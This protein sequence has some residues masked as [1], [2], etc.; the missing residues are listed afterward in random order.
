MW[1]IGEKR[2]GKCKRMRCVL[3][4]VN[5]TL[6]LVK[7]TFDII[8]NNSDVTSRVYGDSKIQ[9]TSGTTLIAVAIRNCSKNS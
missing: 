9:I 8:R 6:F 7:F 4:K 5:A 3:K 2:K 1:K